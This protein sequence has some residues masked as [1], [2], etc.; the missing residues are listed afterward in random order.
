MF[1]KVT[2]LPPCTSNAQGKACSKSLDI[3]RKYAQENG[4]VQLCRVLHQKGW[5]L[6]KKM[7]ENKDIWL[8]FISPSKKV[9]FYCQQ[10]PGTRNFLWGAT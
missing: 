9:S 8:Q 1:T 10:R 5:E 4:I 7:M 3:C 6:Q 2:P